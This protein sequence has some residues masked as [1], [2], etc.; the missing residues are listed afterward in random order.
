MAHRW[1]ATWARRAAAEA[2]KNLKYLTRTD[3]LLQFVWMPVKPEAQPKTP[4]ELKTKLE[5][6]APS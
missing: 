3:F 5:E 2:K 1:T 6:E 4:E